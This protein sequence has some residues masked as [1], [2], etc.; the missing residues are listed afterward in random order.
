M[1]QLLP[2]A[3]RSLLPKHV[4]HA[5][6]RLSFFFNTLYKKVVDVST[7]DKLQNELVVTLCLLEKYFP[8]SFFD[9]MIH[10]TVH[11]IREVRL[12]GPVYFRWMYPFERFMKVLKGYVRNRNHP[13]GCIVECY[14]AEEAIEFC[15]EYLSNVD[16]IGVPS[17]TNVDHKVGAPIPGG[18]ITKVD[19]NLLLQAH[20]YVLEN[21]TIIQPYI[22]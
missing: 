4:R 2:M 20:H 21:T 18:H 19:C 1:Q 15:T 12:C 14:I 8:P 11:L 10:L 17:S 5:I 13:E 3:L 9:I 7:L 16:A 22:E 6:A